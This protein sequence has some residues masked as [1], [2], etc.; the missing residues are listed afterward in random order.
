MNKQ[1]G[2]RPKAIDGMAR[3]QWLRANT[4]SNSVPNK[5]TTG[6]VLDY[7][8]RGISESCIS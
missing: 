1:W 3:I 2:P 4:G 6:I 7:Y 8:S 5:D